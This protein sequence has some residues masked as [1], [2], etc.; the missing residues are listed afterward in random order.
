MN[1]G[2]GKYHPGGPSCTYKGKTVPCLVGF[3]GG[4]GISGNIL[5]NV[6]RHLNDLKFY[7]NDRKN[8]IIPSLLVDG[9]GSRFDLGVLKYICDEITNGPWFLVFR[10]GH[11]FGR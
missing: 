8:G 1:V 3:S 10:M 11:H 5:M 2:Y 7:D 6:L 4:Q 9:N